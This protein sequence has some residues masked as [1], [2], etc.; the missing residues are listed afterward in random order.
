MRLKAKGTR[1]IIG[2]DIYKQTFFAT[3][4]DN[5]QTCFDGRDYRAL[6][7]P[8][9]SISLVGQRIANRCRDRIMLSEFRIRAVTEL[10]TKVKGN[11]K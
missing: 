10:I 3:C 9:A 4:F 8:D 6:L 7:N 11:L 5:K 2:P 1:K